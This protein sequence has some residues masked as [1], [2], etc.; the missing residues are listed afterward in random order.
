MK[1]MLAFLV[2]ISCLTVGYAAG[3]DILVVP[4]PSGEAQY[5]STATTAAVFSNLL[6]GITSNKA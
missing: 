4:I 2:L 3:K 1:R 5:G 6:A